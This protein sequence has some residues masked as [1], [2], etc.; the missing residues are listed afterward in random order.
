[1]NCR[2]SFPSMADRL[3]L[4]NSGNDL[5]AFDAPEKLKLPTPSETL[6]EWTEQS[7]DPAVMIAAM[8]AVMQVAR[9]QPDFETNRLARKTAARFIY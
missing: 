8:E 2:R 5:E 6:R 4:L 7:I 3:R 9:R 1:L